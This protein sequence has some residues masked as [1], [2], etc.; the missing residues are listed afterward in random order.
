MP[1]VWLGIIFGG[2]GAVIYL[3]FGWALQLVSQ[4]LA[5]ALMVPASLYYGIAVG[6]ICNDLSFHFASLN[7]FNWLL[8]L[9]PWITVGFSIFLNRSY[10]KKRIM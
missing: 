6:A 1:Y 10:L 2:I 8:I 5:L 3:G 9:L 4:K 7:Q